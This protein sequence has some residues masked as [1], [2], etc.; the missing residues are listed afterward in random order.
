[1]SG[2]RVRVS[3]GRP[4]LPRTLPYEEMETT[5]QGPLLGSPRLQAAESRRLPVPARVLDLF[6]GI[7]GFSLGLERTAAFTTVAF[8]E[9]DPYCR[10]VLAKHW[11][12]VP[13]YGD[14]RELSAARLAADGIAA[15]ILTGGFPCQ[16]ISVAGRG[17]GLAG[18]RSGLWREYARL[19]GELRPQYAIVE[20]VTALLT[21][22]LGEIL[23]DLVEIGYDAEWH[24]IPASYLGAPHQR[25]RVWIV[26]YPGSGT[27]RDREQRTAGGRHGLQDGRQAESGDD[28]TPEPV[29]YADS[30]G[31]AQR[32]RDF[33]LCAETAGTS[34]R[35]E[36]GI[37]GPLAYADVARLER[38]YGG[39][40][41]QRAGERTARARGAPGDSWRTQWGAE[42][43]V[44]R[45]VNG[46]PAR[47]DR[48]RALGN[49]IVPQ[50]AEYLGQAILTHEK[51]PGG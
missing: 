4:I 34:A 48:L 33:D 13:I 30:T 42:P 14:I 25:D 50:V 19:I 22:G 51:N 40:L 17:A 9:I 39:I 37:H 46:L 11:P 44:R 36:S 12:A 18:A 32:I 7:G 24:C 49:A 3:H 10:R 16:D 20:N 47:V 2:S 23:G 6:A 29:A 28:G 5:V 26:A 31:L 45:V 15:D 38:W 35:Q 41:P 27:V 43:D 8:C 21:R 1:M